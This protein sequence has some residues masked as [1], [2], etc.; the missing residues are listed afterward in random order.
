MALYRNRA[1][2]RC[3][4]SMAYPAAKVLL[5]LLT[6]T[7]A[8]WHTNPAHAQTRQTAQ[9]GI[10]LALLDLEGNPHQIRPTKEV[11]AWA[12]VFLSTECPI[13]RSYLAPLNDLASNWKNDQAS[14]RFYGIISDPSVT[15][16]DASKFVEEYAIKFPVLFDAS[17]QAGLVLR[18]THVPEA[19][20]FNQDLKLT[21]RGRIDDTYAQVGKRRPEPTEHNLRDAVSSVLKG[22]PLS[23]AETKP[24]GCPFE[25]WTDRIADQKVTYTRDIAPL[26]R[27]RCTSCHR[28]TK[29]TAFG[30]ESFKAA[31]SHAESMINF[32]R[33]DG[34]IKDHEAVLNADGITSFEKQLIVR[35]VL[36]L[37]TE[38]DSKDL[39]KARQ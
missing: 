31:Q 19:F 4:A 33:G 9:A 27:T 7:F 30:L 36:A 12:F 11:K 16:D 32:L 8:S 2:R 3:L 15:R 23:V 20:V 24:V 37:A 38:G 1:N 22:V 26:M 6:G 17:G 39:P 34:I 14:I 5:L 29:G 13:A 35:W 18:P 10:R 25:S 21:Y 28:E